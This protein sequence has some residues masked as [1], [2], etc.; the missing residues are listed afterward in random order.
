MGIATLGL[1]SSGVLS[2]DLIDKLKDAD[3]AA[4]VTPI[5][6]RQQ[7]VKL[8]QDA[9]KSIKS[10]VNDLYDLSTELSD[11]TLYDN[12]TS[13]VTGDSIGVEAESTAKEQTLK[14]DVEQ[15]ATRSIKQSYR[16]FESKDEL[17]GAGTMGLTI[18]GT[19][20]DIEI[21]D[22]D[23]L[24]DVA[25][26]ISS[27]T[28]GKIEASI[29]NVGGDEPYRLILKSTGTGAKNEIIDDGNGI[30]FGNVAGGTAQDAIVR[31][32]GVKI[33]RDSNEFDD[34]IE[35]VKITL[36]EVGESTVEI[37]RDTSKITDKME[38]FVD[39]YNEI[40]NTI[41]NLTKYDA[42]KK[43]GAVLQGSSEIRSITGRLRDI[44]DT[45]FS[46]TGKTLEDYGI[47]SDKKGVLSFDKGKFANELK[48]STEDLT[49]F[50]VGKDDQKGIFRKFN[51]EL[52]DIGTRS[53]GVLKSLQTNYND[54]A[55]SLE[56]S[57]QKA[58]ERLD[59]RYEILI[60]KF[61]SYDAVIGKLQNSAD[62]L[63]Q[64]IEA[65]Y[66]KK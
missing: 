65:Q 37:K 61:A 5:E 55:K 11:K 13:E 48:S 33:T 56:E 16:K 63:S 8:K 21:T 50:F 64:I 24:Q 54:R 22:T 2:N 26:K 46:S 34:L 36:K 59:N 60:K 51:S 53:S 35:G 4:T 38:K 44:F 15:L 62:Y 47:K 19:T 39:K 41:S 32:D 40:L 20:Y 52:F 14:L 57:L 17:V 12:T 28:D 3:R 1:G 7:E 42:E 30:N 18:N 29:L 9:L 23:T 58:K 66:A 49:D 10:L 6:E 43:V 25:D 45:T 31:M 27:Q